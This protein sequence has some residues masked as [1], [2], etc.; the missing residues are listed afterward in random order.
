M[1]EDDQLAFF[2]LFLKSAAIDWYD[3]LSA[4]QKRSTELLLK[5]FEQ[6][7]C[8]SPIDQVLN[9][10]SVFNR[11]QKSGEK[12][13]DYVAAMQK[14]VRRIPAVDEDL[15][16]CMVLRGL[17]PQIRPL[18][19]STRATSTR[20]ETSQHLPKWQRRRVSRQREP[21]ATWLR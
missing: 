7:F 13:R 11:N 8:P 19:F 12:V 18:S 5:E 6:Y 3:R 15:L 14:L 9:T 4:I 1:P 21:T 20:S 2:P 16:K 17:E 10:E